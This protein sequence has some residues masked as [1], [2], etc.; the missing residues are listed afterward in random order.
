MLPSFF[1]FATPPARLA[2]RR[3]D[4]IQVPAEFL[5]EK[6]Q[7]MY[8]LSRPP[9]LARMPVEPPP[10]IEKST[11]PLVV[12]VALIQLMDNFRVFEPIVGFSAAAHA[13][14]LSYI[15][16]DALRGEFQRFGSAA[17]TSVPV[18]SSAGAATAWPDSSRFCRSRSAL[19]DMAHSL[20]LRAAL[21]GGLLRV[22][23]GYRRRRFRLQFH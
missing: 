16:F 22:G 15:I 10:R 17:A 20:F 18:S 1:Y 19:S 9:L 2:V 12:F 11:T 3:A 7:Q 5:Q 8:R 21:A 6:V 13:T 14:S 23:G 4:A